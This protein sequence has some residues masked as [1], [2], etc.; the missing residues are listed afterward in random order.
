M[1]LLNHR[2]PHSPSRRHRGVVLISAALVLSAACGVAMED[3][4][5]TQASPAAESSEM[6]FPTLSS[7]FS[8][9]MGTV[10]SP[11]A[12]PVVTDTAVATAT[13]ALPPTN[14]LSEAPAA[15]ATSLPAAPT[16]T[17]QPPRSSPELATEALN[18]INEYR[19]KAGLAAIKPNP[20]LTAAS[21]AY[22]KYMGE[23]NF[24]GHFGPNGSSPSSRVASAGYAGSYRG[25]VL[26]AGQT[27]ALQSVTAWLNSP[28]HSSILYD[29]TAIEGGIAYVYVPGSYY[30]H[31]WALVV[32][33]P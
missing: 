33:R 32:G 28:A 30:G 11:T 2:R 23:A 29:V 21:L 25:E 1:G 16:A 7:S 18:L 12:D 24:F 3:L 17:P 4:P 8:E 9:E 31:Y 20:N 6:V 15:T 19:S 13:P 27:S 26:N 14:T 10:A 5:M 22:A